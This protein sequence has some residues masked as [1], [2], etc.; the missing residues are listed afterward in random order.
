M[1]VFTSALATSQGNGTATVSGHGLSE[2]LKITSATAAVPNTL[3]LNDTIN[4]FYMP[5]GATIRGAKLRTSAA[6]DSNGSPTLTLDVG[7]AGSA[8]RIFSA[9]TVGQAGSGATFSDGNPVFANVGY[10]FTAP[11]LIFATV[12]AAG[13]TKVAGTVYLDV[14]YTIEGAPS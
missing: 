3:A 6:L 1:A 5:A 2:N 4:L 11:T 10:Q 12:H 14:S 7:D 9:S 13:A 8:T